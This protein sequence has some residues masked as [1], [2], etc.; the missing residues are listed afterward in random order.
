MIWESFTTKCVEA[1]VMGMEE[2]LSLGALRIGTEHLLL[3]LL[4][5]ESNLGAQILLE[6]GVTLH[7]LKNRLLRFRCG[8]SADPGRREFS[9]A[10]RR[11]FEL[12]FAESTKLNQRNINTDLLFLGIATHVAGRAWKLISGFQVDRSEFMRIIYQQYHYALGE[13]EIRPRT[14]EEYEAALEA[15]DPASLLRG[16]QKLGDEQWQELIQE[17]GKGGKSST[18]ILVMKGWMTEED[19]AGFYRETFKMPYMN[20]SVCPVDLGA[21]LSLP[22]EAARRYRLICIGRESDEFLVAMAQPVN[23]RVLE[24]IQ[25]HLGGRVRAFITQAADLAKML[26]FIYEEEQ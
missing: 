1:I 11:V 2:A 5:G 4:K 6:R 10:S 16:R 24:E 22:E 25:R 7:A 14:P 9:R 20:L 18:E 15:F 17:L 12:A 26:D 23:A 19:L 21:A 3:G 8:T 13:E